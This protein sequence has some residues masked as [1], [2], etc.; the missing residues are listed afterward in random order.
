[1]LGGP[2]VPLYRVRFLRLDEPDPRAPVVKEVEQKIGLRFTVSGYQF[3]V[4]G[5]KHHWELYE[6][7]GPLRPRAVYT[8]P[9]TII[10]P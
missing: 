1:M 7:T 6:A 10:D 9:P 5:D 2:E 3:V 4:M 8:G